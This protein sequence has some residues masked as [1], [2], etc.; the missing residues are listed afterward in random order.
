[1][2]PWAFF[3]C[4]RMSMFALSRSPFFTNGICDPG[5]ISDTGTKNLLSSI[6]KYKRLQI[7]RNIGSRQIAPQ[8]LRQRQLAVLRLLV[9]KVRRRIVS[10]TVIHLHVAPVQLHRQMPIASIA[11]RIGRMEP[12]DVV[13]LGVMLDLL[14]RRRKIVRVEERLAARIATRASP[15]SPANRSSHPDWLCIAPPL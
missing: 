15:A 9:L 1:M 5:T 4:P 7:N 11:C 6:R 2:I 10:R 13:S 14:K 12:D 8:L 3:T